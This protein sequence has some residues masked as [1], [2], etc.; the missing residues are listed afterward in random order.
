MAPH[1]ESPPEPPPGPRKTANER[2][3]LLARAVAMHIAQGA[4]V[5][6]Q[7]DYEAVVV[8]GLRLQGNHGLRIDG[9]ETRARLTVDGCGNVALEKL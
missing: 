6:S 5:E 3:Q 2:Q 7:S 9:G 1:R 8:R 4:R